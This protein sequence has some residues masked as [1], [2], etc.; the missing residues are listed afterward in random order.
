MTDE[1]EKKI[2]EVQGISMPD[3][4]GGNKTGK[5]HYVFGLVWVKK[6]CIGHWRASGKDCLDRLKCYFLIQF[7]AEH[8]VCT[9]LCYALFI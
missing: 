1:I 5:I 6:Q 8:R 2:W 7:F 4:C 3:K 9:I